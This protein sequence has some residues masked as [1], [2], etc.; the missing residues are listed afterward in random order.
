M[1]I[2][3]KHLNNF[4]WYFFA[5]ALTFAILLCIY[6]PHFNIQ[7]PITYDLDGLFAG[8]SIKGLI[9][10]GWY[11][12]NFYLGSPGHLSLVD[13]PLSDNASFLIIKFLTFFSHSYAVVL[14]SFYFLTF[15]L[16]TIFSFY[17]FQRCGLNRLF[18]LVASL[19]FTFI[20]YHF[21][22]IEIGHLL[23]TTYY[24]VPI[25][26]LMILSVFPEK[27]PVKITWREMILFLILG[28]F[29]ASSG[30]Y[31]AFFGVFFI[32][33]AG[34][35]G[36][37]ATKN[38]VSI[39]KAILLSVII[40]ITVLIN[41]SPSI[42]N[43]VQSGSNAE[44]AVRSPTDSEVFGLKMTQM[45]L[46]VDQHR[47]SG[48]NKSKSHYN[49]IAPLVNENTMVSLGVIGS[50][51]FLSLLFVLLIPLD[52]IRHRFLF[53]FSRLTLFGVLLGT[54]GGLGTLF[55]FC[56]SPMIRSYNRIS[57]FI[58]FFSLCAFFLI[59]QMILKRWIPENKY[60]SHWLIAFIILS[61]GLLD[62]IP[63]KTPQPIQSVFLNDE[64]FIVVIEKT[65]P[66]DA[67][68]FQLPFVKFP[69]N[70]PVNTMND[71]DH[72]RAYLH[73]HHLK[74]S[75]GAIKGRIVSAWQE[76]ISQKKVSEF[77][78][79]IA[80][81]NFSGVYIDRNG[82]PDHAIALESELKNILK[83]KPLV[84][85]DQRFAFY[86]IRAYIKKISQ[87]MSQK[88]WQQHLSN[89]QLL[90]HHVY[91]NVQ[92]KKSI[93]YHWLEEF[94]QE[95]QIGKHRY[96]AV[97]GKATL[98]IN[99]RAS[100]PI[101]ISLRLEVKS[102]SPVW[103]NGNLLKEKIL[104]HSGRNIILNNVILLPGSYTITFESE[105]RSKFEV[106]DFVVRPVVG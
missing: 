104:L 21:M 40:S 14:N 105:K 30:I 78:K 37:L 94:S 102:L 1:N 95:K 58:A 75:Y 16:V 88:E 5:I 3:K 6:T 31:Y 34:L 96:H 72:F 98:E 13:F 71:Y 73:S 60:Q 49:K 51:G 86:D 97:E 62:E 33:L 56:I 85:Q 38:K 82:Y 68:V 87:Q 101:M 15:F 20:P 83:I 55:A 52:W 36:S 42:I 92:A 10:S 84:S 91:T 103:I 81:A 90:I 70:P 43:K 99:N 64:K 47:L 66:H 18:S 25:Y 69:E 106:I 7:I 59:L 12:N 45:I 74:W 53:L 80:Y 2:Q 65:L 77:L 41:I 11:L 76:R 29:A 24:V 28:I 79:E 63:R 32:L 61:V 89:L 27:S 22:R 23:L 44:V 67:Q 100:F 46:P 26:V 9:E 19:L 54:I 39:G 93:D 50:L 8:V 4:L 48:F 17:V 35:M 57:I